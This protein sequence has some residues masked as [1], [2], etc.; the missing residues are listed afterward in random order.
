MGRQED[1]AED[2]LDTAEQ[3]CSIANKVAGNK[4]SPPVKSSMKNSAQNLKPLIEFKD[5]SDQIVL[6]DE[7]IEGI[8]SLRF[9][10]DEVNG[11]TP[12]EILQKLNPKV[13]LEDIHK[14]K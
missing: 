2:S 3:L 6:N 5:V 8:I 1:S 12:R 9:E 7:Y 10:R 4:K 14:D 11:D 13:V